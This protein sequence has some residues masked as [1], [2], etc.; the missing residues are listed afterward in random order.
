GKRC[1]ELRHCRYLGLAKT[2]L[3]HVAI[4][5]AMNL[6]RLVHWWTGISQ[7][8]TRISRFAALAPSTSPEII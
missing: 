1:F 8:Q 3:Q 4:A 7:S 2:R 6:T 5:A